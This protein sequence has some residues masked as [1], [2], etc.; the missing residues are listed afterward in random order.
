MIFVDTSALIP[1]YVDDEGPDPLAGWARPDERILLSELARVEFRSVIARRRTGGRL[2]PKRAARILEEFEGD[3]PGYEWLPLAPPVLRRAGILVDRHALRTLD[4]L[5]LGAA[6][7][8][9][10]GAPHSLRFLCLDARLNAAAKAEGLEV[11]RA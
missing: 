2:S 9:V 4:A 1:R 10:E 5:H 6:L 3:G 8:A 7:L 11:L